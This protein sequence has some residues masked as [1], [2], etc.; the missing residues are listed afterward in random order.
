MASTGQLIADALVAR[1]VEVVHALSPGRSQPHALHA[2]ARI[3][4]QGVVTYPGDEE[5]TLFPKG[6]R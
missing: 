4:D 3:D 1:G 2:A 6:G 5:L